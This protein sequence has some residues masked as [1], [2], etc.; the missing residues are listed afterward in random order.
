MNVPIGP[1]NREAV[2]M[3][4]EE[5]AAED[6]IDALTD[7]ERVRKLL[8]REISCLCATGGRGHFYGD[9]RCEYHDHHCDACHEEGWCT[10]APCRRTAT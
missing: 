8:A 4:P 5:I 7:E 10:A 9:P 1:G 6:A 2:D 3:T